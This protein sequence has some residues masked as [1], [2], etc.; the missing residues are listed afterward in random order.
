LAK[1]VYSHYGYTRD[2]QPVIYFGR[3]EGLAMLG[4]WAPKDSFEKHFVDT[5]KVETFVWAPRY[6]AAVRK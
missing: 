4:Q 1:Y 6:S 2:T 5:D 3:T